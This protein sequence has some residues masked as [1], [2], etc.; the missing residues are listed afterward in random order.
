MKKNVILTILAAFF[1]ASIAGGQTLARND[2]IVLKIEEL[3]DKAAELELFSGSVLVAK[4]G[5]VLF[6]KACGEANKDFHIRNTI[7]T[8]FNVASITKPFTATAIMILAQRGLLKVNDPVINYLPD[9]RFGKN[10]T[11]HHLLTHTAGFDDYESDPEYLEKMDQIRSLRGIL[12]IIYKRTLPS[13]APGETMRYSNSGAVILGAIIEK[14]SGQSFSEFL[15][16]NI[17]SPLK[18]NNTC[19]KYIEDVVEN[20]AVGYIRKMSGGY[21]NTCLMVSPA[22]S[23]T[24]LLTTVQDLLLFDHALYGS[25]L[26]NDD[27]KKMMFTPFKRSYAYFWGVIERFNNTVMVHSGGQP[28][29]SAWFRRYV[30]D[31]YVIIAL[32]NY[33]AGADNIAFEIE[34]ILFG[35][36]YKLPRIPVGE[37][38]YTWIQK[39]GLE[40]ITENMGRILK[41]NGYQVSSPGALNVFGYSLLNQDD[42]EMAIKIFILNSILFK[43]DANA[44]EG[45]GE[46]YSKAGNKEL[47]IRNYEKALKLDP[48][49]ANAKMMLGKL[50]QK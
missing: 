19:F 14:V 7:D 2:D 16:K 49:N 40:K 33:D 9:F 17:F 36:E 5:K 50:R 4:E 30:N 35:K 46:A 44:F 10:I 29:F 6:S 1:L 37:F 3:V 24:G 18:M 34:S 25:D 26:L 12:E 42:I 22:S 23:A 32:S 43:N 41:E 15:T 48:A 31:K 39:E 28:G 21:K 38:L 47:A 13:V 11:I 8:K 20:R 45:L 27:Y